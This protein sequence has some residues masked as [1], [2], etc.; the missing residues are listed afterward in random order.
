MTP[1]PYSFRL[2]SR[3]GTTHE[4]LE[5]YAYRDAVWL[6]FVVSKQNGGAAVVIE[7]RQHEG[8]WIGMSEISATALGERTPAPKIT[9]QG[10]SLGDC[11]AYW[12]IE[13]QA[14][15]DDR[16][17]VLRSGH[18]DFALIPDEAICRVLVEHGPWDEIDGDGTPTSLVL[19]RIAEAAAA[20]KREYE[21]EPCP[22]CHGP[23]PESFAEG[24]FGPMC[25]SC[26]VTLDP[27]SD[28]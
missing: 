10:G 16:D 12:L 4:E 24:R 27:E 11:V 8:D 3:S 20:L 6:A 28:R 14:N 9:R 17:F 23:M 7:K 15:D 18:F 21:A 22:R 1:R 26:W 19:E 2:V 25:K 13:R 5:D